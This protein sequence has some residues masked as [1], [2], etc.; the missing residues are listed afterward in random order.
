MDNLDF[1]YLLS[2]LITYYSYYLL[3]KFLVYLLK[4][5]YIQMKP[6]KNFHKKY[7]TGATDSWV[8]VTGGSDGIGK[9]VAQDFAKQGFNVVLVARTESK[10]NEVASKIEKDFGVKTKCIT[11]DFSRIDQTY[12]F[13]EKTFGS[14]FADK[15]IVVLVNNVGT[16]NPVLLKDLPISDVFK[17]INMNCFPQSFLTLLFLNKATNKKAIISLS[18]LSADFILPLHNVYGATKRFNDYL[19]K[20]V[21]LENP[22]IDILSVKPSGVST[23]LS[24]LKADGIVTVTTEQCSNGILKALGSTNVT[25]GYWIHIIFSLFIKHFIPKQIVTKVGGI[26]LKKFSENRKEY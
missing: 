1:S 23:P 24:Q 2:S 18:S 3:I 13:Y 10:L 17:S 9:A 14:L 5:F 8:I 21:A 12:D 26:M 19:S 16:V 20:G 25:C 15:N 11:V 7:S 4:F 22:E 6:E